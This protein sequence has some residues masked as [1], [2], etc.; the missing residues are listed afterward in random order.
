MIGLLYKDITTS[1]KFILLTWLL[2]S[3]FSI[4]QMFDPISMKIA[5]IIVVVFSYS[6]LLGRFFQAE[7]K[8]N[9]MVLLKTLPI[10]YYV[11]VAE[12]HLLCMMTALSSLAIFFLISIVLPS[13]GISSWSGISLLYIAYIF[14]IG[15]SIASLGIYISLRWGSTYLN[16]IV[17]GIYLLSLVTIKYILPN[18]SLSQTVLKVIVLGVLPL[19]CGI[20]FY[21]SVRAVKTRNFLKD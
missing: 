17:M 3:S 15:T 6:I 5:L 21:M 8:D 10:S 14:V 4:C 16:I 2:T 1:K 18:I 9:T 13:V 19:V 7:E 11:I 20:L 12:K